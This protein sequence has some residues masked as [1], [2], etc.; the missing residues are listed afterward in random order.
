VQTNR[1]QVEEVVA[2]LKA[3]RQAIEDSTICP[4]FGEGYADRVILVDCNN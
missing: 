3:M 4:R 1:E 2:Y